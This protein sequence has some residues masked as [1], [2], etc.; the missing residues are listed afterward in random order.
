M[1]GWS[2]FCR[3]LQPPAQGSDGRDS[4]LRATLRSSPREIQRESTPATALWTL[5]VS[6]L[7]TGAIPA[8][9]SCARAFSTRRSNVSST[10]RDCGAAAV[11]QQAGLQRGSTTEQ[12]PR[13]WHSRPG[14]SWVPF[15]FLVCVFVCA[16]RCW[17]RLRAVLMGTSLLHGTMSLAHPLTL[18]QRKT[19]EPR[20]PHPLRLCV[21]ARHWWLSRPPWQHRAADESARGQT[22]PAL[23]LCVWLVTAAAAVSV[24]ARRCLW[25]VWRAPGL[26][27]SIA[28][29]FSATPRVG[30]VVHGMEGSRFRALLP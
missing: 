1:C 24:R 13:R 5:V 7:T 22:E 26:R 14:G 18:Q 17:W 23:P 25:C 15:E 21:C 29:V 16:M 11:R 4:A 20:A 30:R 8:A 27:R 9:V 28:S 2:R 10:A 3:V 12:Q 6:G 19:F